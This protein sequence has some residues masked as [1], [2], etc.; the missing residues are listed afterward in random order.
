M[1]KNQGGAVCDNCGCAYK[2]K[3]P[4]Q[5]FHNRKCKDKFHNEHNPRGK[6]AHLNPNHP[7]YD[8]EAAEQR[9]NDED[10]SH[11]G[12]DDHKDC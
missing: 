5:R 10:D 6:F 3:H 4:S 2:K 1:K 7:S 8:E 11:Q 12:W 9:Q